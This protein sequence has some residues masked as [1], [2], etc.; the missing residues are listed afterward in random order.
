MQ[1]ELLHQAGEARRGRMTFSRGSVETPVFMPVGT[2]GAVKA[3]T[4]EELCEQGSE[5]ILANIIRSTVWHRHARY[6][7]RVCTFVHPWTVH[8]YFSGRNKPLR[9]SMR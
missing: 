6:L 7:K 5:I 8:P 3:M 2:Y 4:P 1:F 9:F